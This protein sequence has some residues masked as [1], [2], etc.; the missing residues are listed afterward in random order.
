MRRSSVLGLRRPQW[1]E[2]SGADNLEIEVVPSAGTT[3]LNL[4]HGCLTD[5]DKAHICRWVF[6][7]FRGYTEDDGTEIPNSFEAR[8]ELCDV[9]LVFYAIQGKVAVAQNEATLGEAD[10]ASD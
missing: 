1:T 10:A 3:I 5:E 4:R 7:G 6:V 8:R 9:S 2:V